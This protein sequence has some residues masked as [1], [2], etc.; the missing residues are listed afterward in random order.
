MAGANAL[1]AWVGARLAIRK[2]D[3]FVRGVVLLVVVALVVKLAID[4]VRS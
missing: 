2:G 1:G 4:F 3:R